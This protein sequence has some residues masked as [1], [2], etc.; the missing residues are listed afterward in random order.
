MKLVIAEKKE[1]ALAIVQ[2]LGGGKQADGYWTCDN[3]YAVVP[4][5]GHMLEQIQPEDYD[6]KYKVWSFADLPWVPEKWQKRPTPSTAGKFKVIATLLKT[7]SEVIHAGDPDDE[8]QLIVDEILDYTRW[9]GPVKRVLIND[10]N[11][12]VVQKALASMADNAGFRCLGNVA[13]ARSRADQLYGVNVTRAYTLKARERG[14]DDV[15]HAGRVSLA[16]LGLVVRRDRA[17]EGHIPTYYYVTQATFDIEGSQFQA[18]Y[19]PNDTDPKDDKGRLSDETRAAQVA[20]SVI[21]Q[22][23]RVVSATTKQLDRPAPLPYNLLR[24][25]ADASRMFGYKPDQVMEISQSLKDKHRAITYNRTDTQYLSDEQH[26]DA[27]EILQA[28]G[29]TA[30]ALAPMVA[31]ADP[32]VKSRAFNSAKVTVHHGI[33]PT[34]AT[35]EWSSLT[36]QEKNL[37]LLVARVYVA[38]FYPT[39]LA[40][41]TTLRV[42]CAGHQFECS[43][44]IVTRTGWKALFAGEDDHQADEEADDAAEGATGVDLRKLEAGQAG[45][46]SSGQHGKLATKSPARYTTGTLLGDLASAAKYVKNDRL[47]KALQER[48][49]GKESENGGIGTPATRDSLIKNLFDRGYLHEVGKG[50]TTYVV[51]TDRAREY[52]DLLPDQAKYP[53]MTAIWVEQLKAVAAGAM[54]VDQFVDTVKSYIDQ[55]IARVG[56]DGIAVKANLVPCPKCGAALRRIKGGASVFWACT[57]KDTCGHSMND[58]KGRPVERAQASEI[59]KCMACGRGL[60][61]RDSSKPK[62]GAF[63]GC[64]GFK[65]GCKQSYPDI[66]GK[67]NYGAKRKEPA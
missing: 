14:Y 13:D 47:R 52:Y 54:T 25:Q 62:A 26:A 45:V 41:K 53:D 4:C 37:Y 7:A 33:V 59:H 19:Q 11:T 21:G 23:A 8:G 30:P 58:V 31:K 35:P 12:R 44:E 16:I 20:Q 17:A 1:L 34:Q 56:R 5:Q 28:V 27:A 63:W 18:A 29:A 61:R 55:E 36:E 2:A 39:Q 51:S 60:I 22:P 46:C 9:N 32:T 40:D 49:K 66:K 65:E 15:L 50:K 67:P 38:Q 3:G 42:E 24:L 48:D 43:G 10:N 57:A 6:P 64:S